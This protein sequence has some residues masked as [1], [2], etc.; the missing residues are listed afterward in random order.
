MSCTS[1]IAFK[2]SHPVSHV[3]QTKVS[4]L[5]PRGGTSLTAGLQAATQEME[6]FLSDNK[7]EKYI[8]PSSIFFF[9]SP[10]YFT[11]FFFP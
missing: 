11:L 9:F 8:S 1:C 2:T 10:S 7:Y 6:K 5:K 3:L 4:E